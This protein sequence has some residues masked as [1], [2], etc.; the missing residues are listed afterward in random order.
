MGRARATLL[1]LGAACL[2]VSAASGAPPQQ[3]AVSDL[4]TGPGHTTKLGAGIT[5]GATDFPL[6][7]QIT[8]PDASWAGAQWKSARNKKPPF[9]G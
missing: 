4:N 3:L 5:Y 9:Y 6:A 7:F 2:M 8:P 1:L